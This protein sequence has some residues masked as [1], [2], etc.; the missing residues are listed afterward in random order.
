MSDSVQ[1]RR[2]QPTRLPRPW[3]SPGKNTGA[4]HHF[5]LLEGHLMIYTKA[6]VVKR[7]ED[8]LVEALSKSYGN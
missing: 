2:Q 5:S 1:P 4:G 6:I 3:D 8:R 7:F